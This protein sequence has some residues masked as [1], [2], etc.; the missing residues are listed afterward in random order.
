MEEA[1]AIASNVGILAKRM[2]GTFILLEP[3]IFPS[4]FRYRSV[5]GTPESLAAQYASYEVHFACRTREDVVKARALMAL[6]PGSRMLEDVATRFEVPV[7]Q[8]EKLSLANLFATLSSHGDFME[9]TVERPSLESVFMK[10]ITEHN[11]KEEDHAHNGKGW[12][13]CWLC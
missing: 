1:S 5:T 9:Y 4:Q 11:V 10:V 13:R 8:T 7:R 6:I 2:L 3:S 12:R